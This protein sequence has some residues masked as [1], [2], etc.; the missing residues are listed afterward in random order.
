M[1]TKE[2]MLKLSKKEL[3]EFAKKEIEE[4]KGFLKELK[5]LKDEE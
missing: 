1:I 2:E 3:I 5:K 4:W